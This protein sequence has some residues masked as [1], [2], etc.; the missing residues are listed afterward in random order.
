MTRAIDLV[1]LASRLI[2]CPSVTPK[3]AG[4]LTILEEALTSI[5]FEVHRFSAGTPPEGPVE[6]LFATRGS[7]GRHFGYAGHVDVVPPGEGWSTDPFEPVIKAGLLYG[8]GSV[9]M[10][11]SIAAFVAAC[12]E[13]EEMPG[14]I[15]L[16]ITGDE[17]GPGLYGTVALMDWMAERLIRP[18]MILVGEPTS[19]NRLGDT[20][21]IGRRGS[22]NM[23]ITI[24]GVQGH[25][26]YPDRFD[27][28][29][30]KLGRLINALDELELDQGSE[31]FQ[32]SNLEVTTADV[33][34][35]AGNVIP[36]SASLRLNIRFNDQQRGADLV[37]RVR[38]LAEQHAAGA[39]VEALISGEAFVTEPGELSDIVIDAIK[40]ET[41]VTPQLS[42]SGGTSDSR[43]LHKLCPVV[44]FGPVNATMHKLDEA[45]AI[46]DLLALKEIQKRI[47]RTA[48]S[49]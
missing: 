23:W 34:N 6:N 42:T 19:D 13:M 17:E 49:G 39:K 48:L 12:S 37:E 16:I 27:N 43:F 4:S 14:Q 47:V 31:W 33:G 36:G 38:A 29:V 5:G 8:R 35:P 30:T 3:E 24:P 44:D 26:A 20:V 9:D 22:V 25:V 32:P 10:K 40:S 18:D 45:V 46:E 7:G 15:S 21:K 28:P 2:A 1:D 41:G 11:G